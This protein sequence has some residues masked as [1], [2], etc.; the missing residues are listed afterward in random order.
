MN[1]IQI[2][3][4]ALPISFGFGAIMAYEQATGKPVLQLFEAFQKQDAMF[5]DVVLLVACGLT[6]GARKA[7]TGEVYTANTVA[8]L[9]DDAPNAMEAIAQAMNLLAASFAAPD[10]KKKAIPPHA[11]RETRRKAR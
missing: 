8:D 5:S 3:E 6:N 2:G 7:G 4:K 10:A 1:T 11:N 9:L